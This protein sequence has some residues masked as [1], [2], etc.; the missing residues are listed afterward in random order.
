MGEQGAES[1]H[2]HLRIA[3]HQAIPNGIDQIETH[4]EGAHA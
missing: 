1:I 3:T 2:A 4:R